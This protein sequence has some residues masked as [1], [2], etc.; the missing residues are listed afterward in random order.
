[1]K[2]NFTRLSL[3]SSANFLPAGNACLWYFTLRRDLLKAHSKGIT[4]FSECVWMVGRIGWQT[5]V[6]LRRLALSEGPGK[7]KED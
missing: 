7:Q 6:K 3:Q 2:M 5:R 4:E 1:M